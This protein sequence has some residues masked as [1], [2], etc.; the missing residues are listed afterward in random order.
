MYEMVVLLYLEAT[1]DF[2]G[3]S[4]LMTRVS[5]GASEPESLPLLGVEGVLVEGH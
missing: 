2:L 4:C 5:D 3:H 1:D